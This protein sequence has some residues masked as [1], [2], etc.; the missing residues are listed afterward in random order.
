MEVAN[1]YD[2]NSLQQEFNKLRLEIVRKQEELRDVL[3]R[4]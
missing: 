1:T 4:N 2:A 3:E